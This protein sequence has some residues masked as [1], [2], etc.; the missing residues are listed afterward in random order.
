MLVYDNEAEHKTAWD[1]FR[2]APAWLALKGEEQYADTVSKI[3]SKFLI[4]TD[5]SGIR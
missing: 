1:A 5:Y 3:D 2:K 4:A